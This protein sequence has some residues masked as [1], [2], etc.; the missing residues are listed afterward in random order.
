[1]FIPYIVAGRVRRIWCNYLYY[2]QWKL[3]KNLLSRSILRG[4]IFQKLRKA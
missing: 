4:S 3:Y 1:M 2:E